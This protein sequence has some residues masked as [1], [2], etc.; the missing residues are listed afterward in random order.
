MVTLACS[1]RED[2]GD[3]PC[4]WTQWVLLVLWVIVSLTAYLISTD[5]QSNYVGYFL[6]FVVIGAFALRLMEMIY[7]AYPPKRPNS[8]IIDTEA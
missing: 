3:D 5:A 2:G 4:P 8:H 6:Y 1:S 7:M